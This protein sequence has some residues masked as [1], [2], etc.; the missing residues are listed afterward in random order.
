MICTPTGS[1]IISRCKQ[2]RYINLSTSWHIITYSK[3]SR[4][5]I[6]LL[7][8]RGLCILSKWESLPEI[9]KQLFP[10]RMNRCE[11]RLEES[12]LISPLGKHNSAS[13]FTAR[14]VVFIYLSECTLFRSPIGHTGGTLANRPANNPWII[15]GISRRVFSFEN[16]TVFQHPLDKSLPISPWEIG[17]KWEQTQRHASAEISNIIQR[18]RHLIKYRR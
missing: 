5:S 6:K 11:L 13:C 18:A 14:L 8:L 10:G 3:G 17:N 16:A 4:R 15:I 2:R 1:F 12:K 7:A 9:I